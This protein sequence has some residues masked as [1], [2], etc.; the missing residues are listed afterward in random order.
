LPDLGWRRTHRDSSPVRREPEEARL[1][2]LALHRGGPP[3]AKPSKAEAGACWS[4]VILGDGYTQDQLDT[5]FVQ[6]IKKAMTKRF[7]PI[8]EPYGRYRKF[9]NICA[10]KVA[11][12]T[13]PIGKGATAFKCTGDDQSRLATCDERAA[14]MAIASN[15]PLGFEVDCGRRLR[16]RS[17]LHRRRRPRRRSDGRQHTGQRAALLRRGARLERTPLRAQVLPRVGP[18][19]ATPCA[20][21]APARSRRPRAASR[22]ARLPRRLGRTR[23]WSRARRDLRSAESRD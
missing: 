1:V 14:D 23:V 2:P 15:V 11:S 12:Q 21:D 4:S 10:I 19:L 9:V 18:A 13:S 8:G 20:A 16:T 5:L 7:S 22:R 3:P 17:R 6:H